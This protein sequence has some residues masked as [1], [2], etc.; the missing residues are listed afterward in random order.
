MRS[1][2]LH[3][4]TQPSAPALQHSEASRPTATASTGPLCPRKAYTGSTSIAALFLAVT[5]FWRF[6]SFTVPSSEAV[7][8]AG[9]VG[10]KAM[11][12]TAS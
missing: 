3:R 10:W 1:G 6:H 9:S 4:R 2:S 7:S 11:P 8:R 12:L 5:A